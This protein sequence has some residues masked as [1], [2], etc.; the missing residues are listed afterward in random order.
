VSGRLALQGSRAMRL[1]WR[2]NRGEVGAAEPG[3]AAPPP[4][5]LRALIDGAADGE[6]EVALAA[7]VYHERVLLD[8]PVTLTAADRAGTVTL[9][10]ENGAALTVSCSATVRGLVIETRNQSH[11]ALIVDGGSPVFEECEVLGGRVEV[12]GNAAPVFRRCRISATALAGLCATGQSQPRL[13]ECVLDAVEGHAIAATDQAVAHI[14]ASVIAGAA[15]AGVRVYGDARAVLAGCAISG[16][17]GPGL[18]VEGHAGALLRSCQIADG[19]AEGVRVDGSSA[20][21]DE[22][23]RMASGAASSAGATHPAAPVQGVTLVDCQVSGVAAEGIAALAG[24]TRLIRVRTVGPGQDGVLAGGTAQIQLQ[25]CSITQ[26]P[27][28]GV[29]VQGGARLYAARLAIASCGEDGITAAENAWV[30]LVDSRCTGSGR[31]AIWLAGAAVVEAVG[32]RIGATAGH[33]ALVRGHAMIM[34]SDSTVDACGQRGIEV[35]QSADAVLRGCVVSNSNGG[36][37]LATPHHPVLENCTVT[38][39]QRIGIEIGPGTSAQLHDCRVL[40]AG[41]AGV[42]IGSRSAAR[43]EGCVIQWTGGSG[44]VVGRD[45]EPRVRGST[46]SSAGQHGLLVSDGGRG[47]FVDCDLSATTASAIHVGRGAAPVLHNCLLQDTGEDPLI[48]EGARPVFEKCRRAD[49]NASLPQAPA[50]YARPGAQELTGQERPIPGLPTSDVPT[51]DVPTSDVPTSDVPTMELRLP[52]L[53]VPEPVPGPPVPVL[54]VPGPPAAELP[55]PELAKAEPAGE[56]RVPEPAA[57]LAKAEP[58]GELRVPEPAADLPVKELPAEVTHAGDAAV[59]LA[60]LLAPLNRLVGLRRLK[61]DLGALAALVQGAGRPED[62]DPAASPPGR[63]L[64]FAGGHGTGKKTVARLYGE[65][66]AALGVLAR[67]HLVEADPGS[68]A[69]EDAGQAEATFRQAVGGVLFIDQASSLVPAHSWSVHGNEVTGRLGQLMQAHQHDVVVIAAGDPRRMRQFLDR[70]PAMASLFSRTLRFD[71][72]SS[73]ELA[74]IVEQAAREHHYRIPGRTAAA[75]REL[76]EQLARHPDFGNALSAQQV[77]RQMTEH[78]ALRIASSRDAQSPG[79]L[80]DLMPADLPSP[81]DVQ[82]A[83]TAEPAYDTPFG[84]ALPPAG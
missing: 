22:A 62:A 63:H 52:R 34:F 70:H 15:G 51:S 37:L 12:A 38:G 72:Y 3:R 69:D 32:C 53:R 41:P 45:A 66:L 33:G 9:F 76:F 25:D 1:P 36:I 79:D 77:F 18:L 39:S 57:E 60:D 49:A 46:F 55:V 68:L 7:G 23:R 42:S 8:R 78:H 31:A 10:V 59:A 14:F 40:G 80:T 50:R 61:R 13:E 71:D 11:A 81:D 84:L 4:P 24:Q 48:G 43:L 74:D 27:G 17:G 54:P 6:G 30:K 26:A 65:I 64:V 56:L 20:L 35:G 47:L 21:D 5:P 44:L 29:V 28:S 75:L 58:A 73:D 16:S 2:R 67:G 82:N 83:S 19:A